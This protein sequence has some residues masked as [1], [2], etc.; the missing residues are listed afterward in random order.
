MADLAGGRTR[1]ELALRVAS[2]LVLIPFALFVVHQGG[3][4][5]ACGAAVF[6]AVM[7]YEW[8]RMSGQGPVW[9][10]AGALGLSNLAF[11][12]VSAGWVS[13]VLGASA[14]AFGAL[15]GRG[16]ALG[17]FG[18]LYAGGLPFALQVL[19]E[20]GPWDG[21]AAALIL[22]AIVWASDSGAY[23]AGRG[24][25]GPALSTDSPNKTW[26]GALGAVICSVLSGAIAAGILEADLT[27]WMLFGAAISVA[28][29]LGDLFESQIKRQFDVKDASGLVPGH[30]GIM[31]RVDGLGAVCFLAVAAFLAMPGL[32]G[33]L[34]FQGS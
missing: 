2:A 6:A 20:G 1:S 12:A 33:I 18:M 19:R 23:F 10:A 32:V 34:G 17:A 3:A 26:S 4:W 30:G 21:Q 22:M 5:L 24:F 8:C 16:F 11:L 7:G 28:A 27:A 15:H 13:A 29:Q 31:D 14:L 9:L 25:G